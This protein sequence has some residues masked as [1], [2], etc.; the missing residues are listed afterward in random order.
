[1]SSLEYLMVVGVAMA[2]FGGLAFLLMRAL[3]AASEIEETLF[4]L[5]FG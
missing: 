5:P 2:A 3:V 1:M 4:V